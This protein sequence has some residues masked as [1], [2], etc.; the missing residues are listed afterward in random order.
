MKVKKPKRLVKRSPESLAQAGQPDHKI[1]YR[2]KPDHAAAVRD[3]A[4]RTYRKNQMAK[5]EEFELT[6][7][8]VLRSLS[9]LDDYAESLPVINLLTG[10][11]AVM[12]VVRLTVLA[13]LLDTTY[14]TIWRWSSSTSQLPEPVLTARNDRDRPVYHLEEV[15]VMVRAIGEHLNRFKYYRKDHASTRDSIFQLIDQLRQNNFGEQHHGN[16]TRRQ[17]QTPGQQGIRRPGK[18]R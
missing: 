14:Q 6:G 18:G 5:G 17:G 4:L 9:T 15:R 10:K 1:R 8:T 13:Q 2:M 16:Q 12:R 7:S 11:P 3:R